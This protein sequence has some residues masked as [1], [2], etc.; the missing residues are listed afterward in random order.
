MAFLAA[1]CMS[2]VEDLLFL[3]LSKIFVPFIV[4]IPHF[5]YI[6]YF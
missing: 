5:V 6:Y 4:L 2:L 1:Y 3:L